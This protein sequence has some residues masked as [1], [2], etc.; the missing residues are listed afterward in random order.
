MRPLGR[1]PF[2]HFL[3]VLGSA[4]A[5]LVSVETINAVNVKAPHLER[6]RDVLPVTS[7]TYCRLSPPSA[8]VILYYPK[9]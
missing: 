1:I 6:R 3:Y 8:I 9:S 4:G 7:A 5:I 2:F